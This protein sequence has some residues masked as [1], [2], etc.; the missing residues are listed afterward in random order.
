MQAALL[1]LTQAE[2]VCS[3]LIKYSC[4]APPGAEPVFETGI[5][6]AR[7]RRPWTARPLGLSDNWLSDKE[8]FLSGVLS[9]THINLSSLREAPPS[10]RPFIQPPLQ[11]PPPHFLS[12]LSLAPSFPPSHQHHFSW[13]ANNC[14]TVMALKAKQGAS[15]CVCVCVCVCVRSLRGLEDWRGLHTSP[16]SKTDG[17][18]RNAQKPGLK[19]YA[20][21]FESILDAAVLKVQTGAS[22]QLSAKN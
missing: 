15:R 16:S 3:G 18:C 8:L 7:G 22:M 4:C 11:P 21:T 9:D 12:T 20:C 6:T 2:R 1:L 5:H 10:P 14:L 17:L 19:T 13:H